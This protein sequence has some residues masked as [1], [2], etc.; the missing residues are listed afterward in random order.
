MSDTMSGDWHVIPINDLRE[1]A[2]SEDCWCKPEEDAGVWVHKAM[3][4]RMEH[5]DEWRRQPS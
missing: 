5:D 4:H 2:S 1:H 3:D